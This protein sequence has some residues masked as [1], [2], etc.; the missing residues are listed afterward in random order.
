[1]PP[2]AVQSDPAG[3]LAEGPSWA[4]RD[5]AGR[6]AMLTEILAQVSRAALQ[7]EGRD[8]VLQGIV[9][10]LTNRLP[11]ALASIILLDEEGTHFVHEVWS[12]T[13]D[14]DA[15]DARL[16]E[17]VA[18]HFADLEVG[19]QVAGVFLLAG[20]PLGIPVPGDAEAETSRMN[21]VTHRASSVTC[22]RRRPR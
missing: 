3:W 6:R 5:A 21:F 20:I 4:E 11:V 13:L 17:L 7:G 22:R 10:C 12:G 2:Q 9:D 8:E 15:R 18:Q 14:L 19:G 16:L 1:M